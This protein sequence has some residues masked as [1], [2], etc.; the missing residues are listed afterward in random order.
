MR[1][2]GGTV[3]RRRRK[4]IIERAKGYR[5]RRSKCR[6]LAK[7]AGDRGLQYAFHGRKVKKRDYRSLWITRISG[8]LMQT[9]LSYSRFIK[10]LKDAD[11]RLDRRALSEIALN[12]PAGFDALLANVAG[13][14]K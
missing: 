11:I 10:L 14:A 7:E 3:T 8:A 1:T 9:E 12:D 5:G 13:G 2:K 6:I 4:R